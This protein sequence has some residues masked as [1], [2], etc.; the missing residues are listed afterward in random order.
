MSLLCTN[1]RIRGSSGGWVRGH[2]LLHVSDVYEHT[3]TW[4]LGGVGGVITFPHRAWSCA[5][6]CLWCVRTRV[7]LGLGGVGG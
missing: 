2:V 1:T 4:V 5:A 7:Y 3:Y 6:S